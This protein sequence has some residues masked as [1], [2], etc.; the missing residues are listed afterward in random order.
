MLS[1]F[2]HLMAG[3]RKN[4]AFSETVPLTPPIDDVPSTSGINKNYGSFV[5]LLKK[6]LSLAS[7]QSQVNYFH[8][9]LKL[10]FK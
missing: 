3:T 4:L 1:K 7:F 10:M 9:S 5:N 2:K 6:K 8:L